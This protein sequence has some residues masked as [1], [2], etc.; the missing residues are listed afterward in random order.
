[1]LV[2]F[3]LVGAGTLA[4]GGA[5][6]LW[7]WW[8]GYSDIALIGSAFLADAVMAG[9]LAVAVLTAP[10][11]LLSTA[12]FL[13]ALFTLGAVLALV[14]SLT[15]GLFGFHEDPG[16]ELV[17]TT[18]ALETAGTLLLAILTLLARLHP[19]QTPNRS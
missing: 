16:A 9:S 8:H 19:S 15:S 5:I 3:R 12:A 4:A 6:H 17:P 14:L 11:Q 13:A 18:L 10:P 2:V 1:M 7:L